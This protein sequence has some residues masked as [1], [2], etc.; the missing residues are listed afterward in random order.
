MDQ[1]TPVTVH[2]LIIEVVAA[3]GVPHTTDRE[4]FDVHPDAGPDQAIDPEHPAI[5]RQRLMQ[6]VRLALPDLAAEPNV[7]ELTEAL[8]NHRTG[9]IQRLVAK[10]FVDNRGRARSMTNEL[11]SHA[12]YLR[13]L[14]NYGVHPHADQE[15]GQSHA[16]TETGCLLLV[17]EAHRYLARLREAGEL[18]GLD[19][20][21]P[22]T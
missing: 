1:A 10:V 15:P 20:S 11:V 13:D 14:R 3:L 12:S 9:E 4:S 16:F 7:S 17:I 8:A 21:A 2:E 19:L 18:V 6:A 5:K 22:E